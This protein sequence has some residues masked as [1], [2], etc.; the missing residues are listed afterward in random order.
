MKKIV[1]LFISCYSIF[2]SHAQTTTETTITVK[3]EQK[4][5]F[6]LQVNETAKE[7]VKALEWYF[8]ENKIKMKKRR[9]LYTVWSSIVPSIHS[10]KVDL[11]FQIEQIG[12]NK[13]KQ[14][15]VAL[16]VQTA[17]PQFV[18]EGVTAAIKQN[19]PVFLNTI[20]KIIA[21]YQY[22]TETERLK[23][24]AEK[25]EKAKIKA[26]KK[27]AAEAKKAEEA[28]KKLEEHQNSN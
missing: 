14:S 18:G 2:L 27:A 12:K 25:A 4:P 10:S 21:D 1:L 11:F 28:K 16:A 24:E 26:E 23:K 19:I 9:G 7:T 22:Y 17:E 13:N 8:K 3:R 6:A 20:P 5:A 15:N